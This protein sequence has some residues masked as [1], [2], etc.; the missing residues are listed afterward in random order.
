LTPAGPINVAAILPNQS[1]N[2]EVPCLTN[3]EARKT[4]PLTSLQVCFILREYFI[5][6]LI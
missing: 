6:L 1:A 2:V 5:K 3:G 4:D